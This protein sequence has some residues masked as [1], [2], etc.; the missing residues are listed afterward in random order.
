MKLKLYVCLVVLAMIVGGV[1]AGTLALGHVAGRASVLDR[2]ETVLAS[3]RETGRGV[4]QDF[5]EAVKWLRKSAEQ[6]NA[7]GQ[8][9]LGVMYANGRG[10]PQDF[11]EAVKWYRKAVEQGN[12]AAQYNLGLMYANGRGVKR[13]Y[14]AAYVWWNLAAENGLVDAKIDKPIIA[15]LMTAEQIAKAQELSREMLKKNPK[16]L[17]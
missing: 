6:G 14:V 15:K 13:D 10:V 1:W 3:V 7:T 12:V 5:K 17:K 2:L 4:K 9:N 16:L 11:K 8:F